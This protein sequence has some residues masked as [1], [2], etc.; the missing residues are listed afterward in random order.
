MQH[1]DDLR[2]RLLR[3]LPAIIGRFLA[4]QLGQVQAARLDG[5]D[6]VFQ[7]L[8]GEQ[9]HHS[10]RFWYQG[11]QLA[12]DLR[13]RRKFQPAPAFRHENQTN[14]VGASLGGGYCFL[15][16]PDTANL[17]IDHGRIAT[18]MGAVSSRTLAAV[19]GAVTNASPTSTA[20]TPSLPRRC[21]C[22]GVKM[23]LSL[24]ITLSPG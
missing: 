4:A 22:S 15:G 6:D 12:D 16:A 13:G 19:S 1:F 2:A 18:V 23:P 24:T 21:K 7:R 17:G 5:F 3:N 20:F 11:S 14:K 8:V 9:T 10:G